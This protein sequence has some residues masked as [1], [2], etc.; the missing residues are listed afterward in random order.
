MIWYKTVPK[1][2][3]KQ[4]HHYLF[5]HTCSSNADIVSPPLESTAAAEMCV[6]VPAVVQ[7]LPDAAPDTWLEH[8]YYKLW[9]AWL[10]RMLDCRI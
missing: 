4:S 6:Y 1:Q 9:M 10:S 5:D 8:K 3:F 7:T 2:N